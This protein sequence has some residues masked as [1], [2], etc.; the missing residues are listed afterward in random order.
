MAKLVVEA[1]FRHGPE[2]RSAHVEMEW[3]VEA[4][5]AEA[6]VGDH[7][8]RRV[9]GARRVARAFHLICNYSIKYNWFLVN[10]TKSSQILG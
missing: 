9:A 5:S 7:E 6:R 10:F 1:G 2:S 4:D 8:G 3:R